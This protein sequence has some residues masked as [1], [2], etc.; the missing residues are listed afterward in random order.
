M[1]REEEPLLD[2]DLLPVSPPTPPITI[3]IPW[4]FANFLL[5]IHLYTAVIY[6]EK[7]GKAWLAYLLFG[8]IP[9][10]ILTLFIHFLIHTALSF[11]Y[12]IIKGMGLQLDR[13][14][15]HIAWSFALSNL[16]FILYYW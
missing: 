10:I 6:Y 9:V 12:F 11:F 2:I 14:R 3:V 7:Q 8:I 4:I 1:P 13:I 5:A 16:I 15:L